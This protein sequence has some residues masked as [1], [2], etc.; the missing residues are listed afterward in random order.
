MPEHRGV[1]DR[2]ALHA[3]HGVPVVD[4]LVLAVLDDLARPG[5]TRSAPSASRRPR[6]CRT[7]C[8]WRCCSSLTFS[9]RRMA[10]PAAMVTL[11]CIAGGEG[12]GDA[13]AQLVVEHDLLGV[14]D[15]AVGID[16]HGVSPRRGHAP[17]VGV[18][19]HLVGAQVAAL[20]ARLDRALGGDGLGV[21]VVDDRVGLEDRR[22]GARARRPGR[23]GGGGAAARAPGCAR[24]GASAGAAVTVSTGAAGSDAAGGGAGAEHGSAAVGVRVNEAT[25]GRLSTPQR[26]TTAPDPPRRRGAAPSSGRAAAGQQ[27]ALAE[28]A[29]QPDVTHRRGDPLLRTTQRGRQRS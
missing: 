1:E 9:L 8:R 25:T 20:V 14:L 2:H 22:R 28:P 12:D 5:P 19:D 4:H 18:V 11:S 21:A 24:G 17:V 3:D 27:R 7:A 29:E 26:R 15:R 10:A 13:G 23:R 16:D 6:R